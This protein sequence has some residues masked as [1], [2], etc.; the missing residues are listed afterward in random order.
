MRVRFQCL[1]CDD[2]GEDCACHALAYGSDPL[3]TGSHKMLE[4][5]EESANEQVVLDT[6]LYDIS[7]SFPNILASC[8]VSWMVEMGWVLSYRRTRS[9]DEDRSE[10]HCLLVAPLNP[11]HTLHHHQSAVVAVPCEYVIKNSYS[12]TFSV[13]YLVIR[14]GPSLLR[15]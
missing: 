15:C 1:V 12:A 2:S 9:H 10:H 6:R 5:R 13:R 14:V 11:P 7:S 8:V 4:V 3:L